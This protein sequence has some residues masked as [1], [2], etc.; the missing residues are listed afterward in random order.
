M[1][2]ERGKGKIKIVE[3]EGT[4]R[5]VFQEKDRRLVKCMLQWQVPQV[6]FELHDVHGHFA[7]KITLG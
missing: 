5:L 7:A 4:W 2:I 1:P 6:M 3:V